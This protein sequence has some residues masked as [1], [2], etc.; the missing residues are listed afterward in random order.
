[1]S[2]F[3]AVAKNYNIAD[4][5]FICKLTGSGVLCLIAL[6]Q[7]SKAT[8][9]PGKFEKHF[10]EA[11]GISNGIIEVVCEVDPAAGEQLKSGWNLTPDF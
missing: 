11:I 7:L 5:E 6:I 1:M 2:I 4:R 8:A 10:P 9:D 3:D